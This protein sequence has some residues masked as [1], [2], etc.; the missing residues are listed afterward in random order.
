VV[1]ATTDAPERRRALNA[2]QSFIVQAPAGS[3]KTELLI[4]R[5]LVL[6][7]TVQEPEQVVAI[8]FT[9]K[10][11]AEMRRRVHEALRA[12][13]EPP[14]ADSREAETLRLARAVAVRAAELGWSLE[15][16]PQRLRI[17]TLDAFNV[18]L[19]QHL[20]LLADG[21][22][23]ADIVDDAEHFYRDAARRTLDTIEEQTPV[24]NAVRVLLASLD[25]DFRMLETLL[26]GL[27]PRRDQWLDHFAAPGAGETRAALEQALQR[28]VEDQLDAV[29]AAWPA[30][31]SEELTALL[32]HAASHAIDERLQ[33]VLAPCRALDTLPSRGL[34]ALEVWRA[35]TAL[36]LTREG[37]WRR[38]LTRQQG[39]GP[40]QA[41]ARK[42][43]RAL[44]DALGAHEALREQLQAV[45][46]LPEP[47]YTAL[48]W[49]HLEALKTVLLR[50]AA[51]LK[52]L[53][54]EQR[55]IDF[56]ELGLAALR[57]LGASDA[58]SELLLALD[59]RIQHIL[60]D[61]F[62][63]TSQ[64][65]IKLL[66][67]LTE[68]WQRGDGRT[69]FLV[70]D[71]MQSIY[72]FRDADL[73]LFLRAKRAGIGN[74]QL[75]SLTLTR[76]FRSAPALV[77]WVNRVFVSVFPPNDDF[78]T[79]A[80][81]FTPS[82]ATRPAAAEQ[83]VAVHAL[84]ASREQEIA[85]VIE[86]L[87]AERERAP[88]QS[89]AVLVQSRTHLEGL[90]ARLRARGWPVH[91][92]EIEGLEQHPVAQDLAGLT[93]ALTHLGDRVAWLALL[94][95]PWLGLRWAD[96]EALCRDAPK[97]AVWELMNDRRRVD[98]LSPDGRRRILAARSTLAAA[99]AG[100]GAMS[101]THWIQSVWTDLEGPACLDEP[102]DLKIA[103]QY[104][105]LLAGHERNADLDDPPGL[106]LALDRAQPPS[107]PPRGRG[108]EIMTMHRAK[109]LEFDTVVLLGL[110]RELRADDAKALYWMQRASAA[111]SGDLIFAPLPGDGEDRRLVEFVRAAERQRT[112]AERGRLLYVAATR[113]RERLHLVCQWAGDKPQPSANTL[114]HY[115][116]PN[117]AEDFA[118][119]PAA[120]PS[121]APGP[122]AGALEPVLRRLR[123][124]RS[125]GPRP[126][127]AQP[128]ADAG[129]E[130]SWVGDAAVHVGTVVHQHLQRFAEHGLGRWSAERVAAERD[131][132]ALELKLLG[133]EPDDLAEAT[134]RVAAALT[135]SITDT[136]GRWVLGP[137]DEARSEVRVTV[138]SAEH[139]EHL[140][141]DRTFVEQGRRWIVDFK[142]G[143]H[144]GGDL[145]AF[146]ASEV[147]RYRPQL[148]R[149]ASA[150][151]EI[152]PRPISLA[153]YFPLLGT[154]RT[155][156]FGGARD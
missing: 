82:V 104:F 89:I 127:E 149:Y 49:E 142:T 123:D 9:R 131:T 60:V 25:N 3:G 13:A 4:Q 95:A 147:E 151:A 155:W 6:L 77:D 120:G 56:V 72:R 137:H 16:Q 126:A 115:L 52:I 118:R 2:A 34:P 148:E 40:E 29:A 19:A 53:F 59:R 48:Q 102:A 18:W 37:R 125:R 130:F 78:V 140:R 134:A 42:R 30:S 119:L 154:L 35:A 74:V 69:L 97:Q 67:L 153:L 92:V 51:E 17:D 129:P 101:L 116:W 109:G 58:P 14:D 50:L 28:L 146:L 55:C 33:R 80:A 63:D 143:R 105:A 106:Q 68:G 108:I 152:D 57:A 98:G 150:M 112:W 90:H 43:L 135:A 144:E 103:D 91:A 5:Y 61:E 100:R 12:A 156:P 94:R 139:L 73:S 11:A 79:G 7:T 83:A 128:R 46:A 75:E 93:R 44:L 41:P 87:A 66:E 27:L 8:T 81:G 1:T 32:G 86:I 31:K 107:D 122:T 117:V 10:A 21:V 99:F 136:Q 76:N 113:A 71:P 124:V 121:A 39:F 64:S 133:V 138:R 110:G 36:L 111:T 141:L 45:A 88:H 38:Q 65:Q 47:H 20:P 22:A 114:L 145:E 96:L 23:A 24:G 62:Q 84:T 54:A 15:A 85:R 70:G 132:Y 26:S